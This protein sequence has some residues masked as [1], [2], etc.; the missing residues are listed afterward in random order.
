MTKFVIKVDFQ[1]THE[2][3]FRITA[4]DKD[5]AMKIF[6]ESPDL[7]HDKKISTDATYDDFWNYEM[8]H[9]SAVCFEEDEFGNVI[10]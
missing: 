5:E 7:L 3:E 2:R 8:I 10:E 1:R 9:E 6:D 4:N